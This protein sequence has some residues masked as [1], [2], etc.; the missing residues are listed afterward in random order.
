MERLSGNLNNINLEGIENMRKIISLLFIFSIALISNSFV[1]A[2]IQNVGIRNESRQ[3]A[4]YYHFPNAILHKNI[5]ELSFNQYYNPLSEKYLAS[6]SMKCVAN[7]SMSIYMELY[8]IE[9]ITKN[10]SQSHENIIPLQIQ[11]VSFDE[12]I[13]LGV[14]FEYSL[15]D[16]LFKTAKLKFY[17]NVQ[18][19]NENKP[20]KYT[21]DFKDLKESFGK[22]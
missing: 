7:K 20:V 3:K 12:R 1:S 11:K 8:K 17:F 14:T 19:I 18:N 16:V 10:D 21:I 13:G 6:L 9:L 2:E 4:Q 5:S 15:V 22:L